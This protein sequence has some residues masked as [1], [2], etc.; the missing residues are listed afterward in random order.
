MS[1]CDGCGGANSRRSRWCSPRCY[2]ASA[3]RR[4]ARRAYSASPKGKAQNRADQKRYYASP[5][6]RAR[7]KAHDGLP[8]VKARKKAH[9]TSPEGRIPN[10][11]RSKRY[12]AS[13]K[14]MAH[15][16]TYA[17]KARALYFVRT[18]GPTLAP[19]A[20]MNDDIKRAIRAVQK[21]LQERNE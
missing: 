2:D 5:K 20:Q 14:G 4:D 7:K 8:E 12:R 18:W 17:P 19:A 3:G 11:L 21:A 9:R 6:G 15:R 1:V 16:R 10:R 13:P